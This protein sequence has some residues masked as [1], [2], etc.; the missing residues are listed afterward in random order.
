MLD[1]L[2]LIDSLLYDNGALRHHCR[3]VGKLLGEQQALFLEGNSQLAPGLVEVWDRQGLNLKQAM[4]TLEEC[5]IRH[6]QIH[7]EIPRSVIGALLAD[8]LEIDHAGMMQSV[9][10]AQSE[11]P[12][13]TKGLARE[14]LLAVSLKIRGACE[15]ACALAEAHLSREDTILELLKKGLR[16]RR[17]RSSGQL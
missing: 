3:T 8:A 11:M 16:G 7:D 12:T 15:S 1:E 2:V 14:E 17:Q 5:L 4:V 9:K 10:Q 13:D 6:K